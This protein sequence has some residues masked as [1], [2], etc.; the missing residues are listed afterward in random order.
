MADG[1]RR[2][3]DLGA[4]II[5]V[6][7]SDDEDSPDLRDA[8]DYAHRSGALVVASA[9][10]RDTTDN[11]EDTPR[12]PAAYPGALSVTALNSEGLP[13]YDSIHGKHIDVASPAQSVLTTATGAGDCIYAGDAPT[14]SFATAYV[15]G[16]AA[17]LAQAYP[18]EGP[19]GWSY[20]LKAT[21]QRPNQ[22]SND[23]QI[24]WGSIRPAAALS[25]RPDRSV[26][27]P[28]SPFADTTDS[29]L[30]P[31]VTR[32]KLSESPSNDSSAAIAI[33]VGLG[34][35]VILLTLLRRLRG[36]GSKP[37]RDNSIGN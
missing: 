12:Y 31:P 19:D 29:A 5:V 16:A 27:G 26:R 6:A 4:R 14:S 3:V 20:R 22:D 7:L 36:R 35:I 25:L 18:H 2:S 8:T 17:L 34:G 15:A 33:A 37:A 23:D 10:N 11:K 24:G 21:A 13:T 28:A 1:I 32:V 30:P 9:G